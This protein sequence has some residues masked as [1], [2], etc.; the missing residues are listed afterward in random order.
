LEKGFLLSGQDF[1]RDRTPLEA[2]QD[3]FVDLAHVFVGKEALELQRKEGLAFRLAGIET[4]EPGAIPRH[5]TPIWVG[6]QPVA[7]VSSG[8][9]SPSLQKGIAIAYLPV[10]LATVGTVV[11]LEIRGRKAPGRV[12]PMPFYPAPASRR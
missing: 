5:G 10:A 7:T 8:G 12:V 9:M 2:G 6:G 1:H 11:E 3:R 4:D